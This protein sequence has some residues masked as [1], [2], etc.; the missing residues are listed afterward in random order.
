MNAATPTVAYLGPSGTYS[1]QAAYER[2]GP[3]VAYVEQ[4][5]IADVFNAVASTGAIGVVPQENTIFGAVVET[6]DALAARA[7]RVFVRGTV[8]LA[9]QHC[10]LAK[11]GT[12]LEDIDTVVSHEQA[13]GQCREFLRTHL[14]KARLVGAPSTAAAARDVL[15]GPSTSAAI[16]SKLCAITFP[17]LSVLRQSIQA[18]SNNFTRFYTIT[19]EPDTPLPDGQREQHDGSYALMTITPGPGQRISS[20]LHALSLDVIRMD[21][22]PAPNALPFQDTY[23]L[24]VVGAGPAEWRTH[25]DQALDRVR[26]SGAT[27]SLMGIW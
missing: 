24:E 8:T 21:R 1:H 25:L 15:A 20:V 23:L 4:R 5:T 27:A 22:R 9:V 13:L 11:T 6:Y 26:T 7:D 19:K 3:N 10:L 16:G 12:Q 18:E 17:G 14:P 2:F